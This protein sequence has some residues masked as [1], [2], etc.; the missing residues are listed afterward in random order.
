MSDD[1]V[2]CGLGTWLSWTTFLRLF[3]SSSF[4]IS[5]G[6]SL[7]LGSWE[8]AESYTHMSSSS[9]S[10]KN[11]LYYSAKGFIRH[12]WKPKSVDWFHADRGYLGEFC[13][14]KWKSFIE[15]QRCQAD[16]WAFS[17]LWNFSATVSFTTHLGFLSA[18][19]F[20]FQL[21]VLW[22]CAYIAH[23]MTVR[24]NFK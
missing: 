19:E 14:V 18:S 20:P 13:F 1:F 3:C 23:S 12:I 24:A 7:S 6:L 15:N 5:V 4:L 8:K 21:C 2:K 10:I 17:C 11:R 16:R 22:I 9:S